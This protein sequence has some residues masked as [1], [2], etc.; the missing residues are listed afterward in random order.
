[1]SILTESES[2]K[3]L[4]R[5]ADGRGRHIFDVNYCLHSGTSWPICLPQT[6]STPTGT[7]ARLPKYQVCN[8]HSLGIY[9]FPHGGKCPLQ[10]LN[11]TKRITWPVI[12]L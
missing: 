2:S 1:M 4:A 10:F 3:S 9:L 8:V 12:Q 6:C 7:V 11:G 5:M